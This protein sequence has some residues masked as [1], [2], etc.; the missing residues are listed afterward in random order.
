MER[1]GWFPAV[2]PQ[3]LG[4]PED[5]GAAKMEGKEEVEEDPGSP[6]AHQ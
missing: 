6:M 3:A 5:R 2:L 1:R 4:F